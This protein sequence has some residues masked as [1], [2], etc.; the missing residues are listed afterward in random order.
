[1]SYLPK[2]KEKTK[3][4]TERQTALLNNLPACNYDPVK[5]AELAGYSDPHSAVK[6]M[7]KELITYA[8]NMLATAAPQAVFGIIQSLTSDKPIPQANIK[9]KAAE[10]IL[11]RTGL[12]KKE[13]L[14]VNH[15]VNGGVFLLPEKKPV[16]LEGEYE[17]V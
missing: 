14:D 5:A 8:E 15:K 16:I 17:D 13:T 11:D 3:E 7:R 2:D 6:R 1:M 12:G 4:M 10:S 9:L